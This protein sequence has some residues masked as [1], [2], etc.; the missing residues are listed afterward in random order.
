MPKIVQ[1]PGECHAE[2]IA[3]ADLELGLHALKVA[4]PVLREMRHAERVLEPVVHSARI[5]PLGL[6]QL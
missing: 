5:H 2:D 3:L 1:Q 6:T 4:D